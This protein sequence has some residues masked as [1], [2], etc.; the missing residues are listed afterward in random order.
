M[1]VNKIVL[2]SLLGLALVV[3]AITGYRAYE[4]TQTEE[5]LIGTWQQDNP[6]AT[7]Q[8]Q[9]DRV[10]VDDDAMS[11]V[12]AQEDAAE[13]G[14]Q[15]EGATIPGLDEKF[16]R[17]ISLKTTLTFEEDGRVIINAGGKESQGRWVLSQANGKN[18]TVVARVM[19]TPTFEQ[20]LVIHFTFDGDDR[21]I[22]SDDEGVEGDFIRID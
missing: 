8:S 3:A 9:D 20:R 18:K 16:Q 21:M 4:R 14:A 13:D 2:G 5:R 11:S 1:N 19:Q 10:Q 12:D 15:I 7:F 17:K 6:L 22:V